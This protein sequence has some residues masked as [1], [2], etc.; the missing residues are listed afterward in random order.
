VRSGERLE[1]QA[2]LADDMTRLLSDLKTYAVASDAQR[3]KTSQ[4]SGL[5]RFGV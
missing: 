5:T 1:F 4:R 2:P 3:A